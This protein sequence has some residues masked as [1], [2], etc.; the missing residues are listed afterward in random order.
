M[1]TEAIDLSV[2]PVLCVRPND[3]SGSYVARLDEFE[4]SVIQTAHKM[5]DEKHVNAEL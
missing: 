1:V 2:F 5:G 4:L 3:V